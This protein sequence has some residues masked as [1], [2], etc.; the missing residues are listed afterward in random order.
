MRVTFGSACSELS[1]VLWRERDLLDGLAFTLEIQRLVLRSGDDRW[2]PRACRA[3]EGTLERL[4]STDLIRAVQVEALAAHLDLAPASSLRVLAEAVE[5]PWTE[6]FRNHREALLDGTAEVVR[7]AAANR[8]SLAGCRR[9]P[10]G[11]RWAVDLVDRG[12]PRAR[13]PSGADE[14]SMR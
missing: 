10:G 14:G 9:R 6:I 5:D 7:L 12:A 13:V 8:A 2:L 1:N 11:S 3:V 4:R